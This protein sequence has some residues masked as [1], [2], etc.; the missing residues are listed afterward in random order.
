[1][2]DT[3][4][5]IVGTNE[6]FDSLLTEHEFVLV[7][8]YAPWCGH[9]KT[10]EP[11][12]KKASQILNLKG[13]PVKLVKVDATVETSLQAK[14][15]VKGYPTLKFFR[16]GHAVEYEGDRTADGIVS[17]VT[18]KSGP[19]ST[20]LADDAAVTSFTATKPSVVGEFAEGSN[21]QTVF[22]EVAR[23]EDDFAFGNRVAPATKLTLYT[24]DEGEK[25]YSGEFTATAI[26][27]W[28]KVEG[29]P[30]LQQLDQKVWQRSA[31]SRTS[32]FVAFVDT[33]NADHMAIA[34]EVAKAHKGK[35]ATTYM[36]AGENAELA[37]RWGASGNV[38]PTAVL[39]SYRTE[40]PNL[41]TWDEENEKSFDA[42]ALSQFIESGLE[43]KYGS[44]KKSEPVPENNDGPVTTIV[45]KTFDSIVNDKSKDVFVE[46]YAPWCGHCK[47]LAPIWDQLGEKF[48]KIDS[49]V[50]GKMDA[51]ANS[52]PDDLEIK[53]FPTIV[54]F[55][56]GEN[57][58][59]IRYDGAREVDDFVK[60]I[61]AN[62]A[63][64]L[65][66]G[67]VEFL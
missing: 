59:P 45:G 20:L 11:E 22:V 52:F 49:V 46:F 51:T 39:I 42:K 16:S 57:A 12:Y 2:A 24:V 3:D 30:S 7:E 21:D 32:L 31:A 53:G 48:S 56:A 19:V 63:T 9:C 33:K 55:P 4:Y 36:D 28:L 35:V 6:N 43:G 58:K 50:I 25:V 34:Q 18:K 61:A 5:V 37:E 8:F 60:F 13:S 62:A 1:L 15:D 64:V 41:I 47:K 27:N 67:E 38:F 54:F 17:W 66:L 23:S 14:F 40:E 44:Y 65:N 29:F 26:R 10:L